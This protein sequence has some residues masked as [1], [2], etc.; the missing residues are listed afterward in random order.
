LAWLA[1]GIHGVCFA[2]EVPLPA[3]R[4]VPVAQS[5]PQPN[6]EVSFERDGMELAIPVRHWS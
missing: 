6:H 2:A 3:A 1:L 5:V 4:P